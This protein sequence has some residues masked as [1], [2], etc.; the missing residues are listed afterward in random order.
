ML[1]DF[2]KYYNGCQACQ[3]FR[4][5]QMVPTS[6]MN[7]IIKPWPFRGWGMDMIDKINPLSSKS[8]QYILTIMD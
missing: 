2:F 4:K 7:P 1:E 8:H 5:I 6:V 3:K